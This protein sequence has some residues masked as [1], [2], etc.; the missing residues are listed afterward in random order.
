MGS[1]AY[2]QTSFVEV[3]DQVKT[4]T[5]E[6]SIISEKFLDLKEN[7]KLLY[8]G[9]KNLNDQ[10][11]NQ[12]SFAQYL[13]GALSF[14]LTL[15]GVVLALYINSL[16]E[17][18]KTMKDFVEDAK[19]NIDKLYERLRREETI[20]L[21]TR[22][23]EVPED[24]GNLA[25]LLLSRDLLDEDFPALKEAYLKYKKDTSIGAHVE[26]YFILFFQHF[27]YQ[28]FKDLELKA[29][30]VSHLNQSTVRSMFKRD[31]ENLIDGVFKFI[32]EFGFEDELHKTVIK[33]FFY[34]YSRSKFQSDIKLKAHIRSVITASG[35]NSA[36]II[37]IAQVQAP[38]D[39]VFI[40]WLNSYLIS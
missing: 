9:A 24:I 14:L 22:L 19:G 34:H 5:R 35:V 39:T 21:L 32:K 18:I 23:R 15:C 13:L 12:I 28:V 31:M 36:S 11:S 16:Y 8:D 30:A 7:Y 38:N 17:K 37:E 29:D 40:A 4:N 3:R 25:S 33:N 10:L 1:F 6:I 20:A 27:S 26:S 2:A